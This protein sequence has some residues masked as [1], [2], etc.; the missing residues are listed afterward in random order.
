[1]SLAFEPHHFRSTVPFYAVYRVPYPDALIVFVAERCN[2]SDRLA[3]STIRS[4]CRTDD[5]RRARAC[6]QLS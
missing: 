4:N 3:R 5:P 2:F 1:M 6:R